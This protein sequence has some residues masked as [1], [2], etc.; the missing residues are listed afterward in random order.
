MTTG[1]EIETE[2][3]RELVA[4]PGPVLSVYFDLDARPEMGEDAEARWQGLCR[5][6]A[7]RG[8]AADDVDALTGR[9]L[10]TQPGSGVLAAFVSEG[11][12]RLSTVLPGCEQSDL[13]RPGPLPHLL[14][15]LA[16][17]QDHPAH[18][19][20]VVDRTGADLQLYPR[21]ATEAVRRTITGP[22]DEIERNQPG[23]TAQMRY[24]HRAEDSWEHNAG[25]VAAILG[26]ALAEVD[27]HVLMLAGDVRARQ[28]LT[29]H[30]PTW[31]RQDV[32]IRPVSGSR[33]PDG[34]WPERRIQVDTETSRAGRDETA[35]LLRVL[36][37][38]RSPQGR[39]VEG[40]HATLRALAERRLRTLL[41]TDDPLSRD[42]A[43]FGPGPT[44]VT[45]RRVPPAPGREPMSRG[46]LA[47]VAVRSALL[48]GADVRVLA[49]GAPGAPSQGIGGLTHYT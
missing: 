5:G 42:S 29:K 14:P 10:S 43:W 4:A 39:T 44:H 9:F 11:E 24:Q 6:L 21:G 3:L 25:K 33:S 22:D 15:L 23:G 40:V 38:G 18:V 37:E 16:W 13:A 8:A 19:V 48:T 26:T 36:D 12:V 35:A 30:L 27:A 49:P 41:I 7:R 45:D 1:T 46:P 28:Y 32:S 31:V 17:R 34:A 47:D 20:A 2:A